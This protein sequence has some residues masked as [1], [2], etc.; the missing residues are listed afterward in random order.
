MSERA[1]YFAERQRRLR[2]DPEFAEAERER[3][4]H[5]HARTW[6]KRREAVNARRRARY[7]SR[8][9]AAAKPRAIKVRPPRVSARVPAPRKTRPAELLAL[10]RDADPNSQIKRLFPKGCPTLEELS[11]CQIT[12]QIGS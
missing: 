4:R 10:Y 1:A 3:C 11:T 7:V 8:P 12:C 6:E 2:E 5:Y 9:R